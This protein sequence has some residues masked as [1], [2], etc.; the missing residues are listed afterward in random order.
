M[1][2]AAML[3][4]TGS[5]GE[6]QHPLVKP[7]LFIL[8]LSFV[9]VWLLPVFG[10]VLTAFRSMDDLTTNGF[11]TVPTDLSFE[12]F[13]QAWTEGL[14]GRYLYNSFIITIPSLA[15]TLFLSSLAAFALA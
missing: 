12:Y 4:K 5:V 14:L 1:A 13:G 15:G 6:V 3:K 7:V 2:H 10:G 8:M 9:L 11:W